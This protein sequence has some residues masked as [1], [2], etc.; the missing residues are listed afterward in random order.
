MGGCGFHQIFNFADNMTGL[1]V[2]F[3]NAAGDMKGVQIGVFNMI[4]DHRVPVLPV[5][6]GSF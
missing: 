3:I 6:N 5:A 1:Q 2:G 4:C